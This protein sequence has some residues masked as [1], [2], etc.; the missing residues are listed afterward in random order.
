V[1]A[2]GIAGLSKETDVDI[3]SATA[4]FKRTDPVRQALLTPLGSAP[5][6]APRR[7]G[8]RDGFDRRRAIRIILLKGFVTIGDAR[9]AT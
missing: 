3:Q 1:G 7:K 5:W 2:V 6:K 8:Y 9:P 4:E